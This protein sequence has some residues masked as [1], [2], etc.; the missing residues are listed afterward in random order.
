MHRRIVSF[1]KLKGS[2]WTNLLSSTQ[3]SNYGEYDY[4]VIGAGSAGC[5][6]ANKL[7]E[8]LTNKVLLIESGHSNFYNPWIHIPVGYLY[9]INNPSTDHRYTT[10]PIP[11]LN[12][13]SLLYPRGKGIGGCSLINGMIYM[14][15]QKEDY[16]NWAKITNDEGWNWENALKRFKG[17]ENYN[18]YGFNDHDTTDKNECY[19]PYHGTSGPWHVSKQ[20]LQWP[21]LDVFQQAM[22]ETLQVPLVTDFNRGSNYGVGYFDVNQYKGYRWSAAQ[23]FLNDDILTTRKNNLHILTNATVEKLDFNVNSH[24]ENTTDNNINTSTNTDSININNNN[25]NSNISVNGVYFINTKTNEKCRVKVNKEVCLCA[26][27]LG[28]VEILERSGVGN[29]H[30]LTKFGECVG[31]RYKIIH[32]HYIFIIIIKNVLKSCTIIHSV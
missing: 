8:N 6:L 15:G 31:T 12:N 4:I 1:K 5:L 25:N 21:I 9:C 14:R 16:D 32:I 13:R 29:K 22:N 19:K 28:N 30:L 17:F 20:R 11:N 18:G 3:Y 2:L 7:S 27:S 26:G 23:A 24:N 10:L